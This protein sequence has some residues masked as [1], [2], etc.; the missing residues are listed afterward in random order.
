MLYFPAFSSLLTIKFSLRSIYYKNNNRST[1]Y[2]TPLEVMLYEEASPLAPRSCLH[3]LLLQLPS[4]WQGLDERAL[5][6]FL[7]CTPELRLI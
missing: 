5:G 1:A 6:W 2:P 7:S 3:P 4:T